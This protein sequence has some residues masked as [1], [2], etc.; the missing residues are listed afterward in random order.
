MIVYIDVQRLADCDYE[1]LL[2]QLR[3][4]L[5]CFVLDAF[6]DISQLGQ[7]FVLEFVMCVSHFR[8]L[9]IKVA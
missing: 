3:V 4:A 8:P 7:R 5:D 6:G 2:I 1:M 9:K